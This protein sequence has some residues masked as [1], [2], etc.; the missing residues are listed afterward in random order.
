MTK[1]YNILSD[2]HIGTY[3]VDLQAIISV[4]TGM[5]GTLILNGDIYEQYIEQDSEYFI[6]IFDYIDLNKNITEVIY[7]LG[8]HDQSIISLFP[9]LKPVLYY[10]IGDILIT[11]GHQYDPLCIKEPTWWTK[12]FLGIKNF[13]GSYLG[14]NI[15]IV[16]ERL[17]YFIIRPKLWKV[18]ESAV[19]SNPDKIVILG[20]THIPYCDYPYYNSGG[21]IDGRKTFI[22]ITI[23]ANEVV[24]IKLNEV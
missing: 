10:K 4:I 3:G 9:D 23:D 13:I 7:V 15:K 21:I 12:I 1:T 17:F 19:A 14:F 8:N 18:Q 24:I 20:H 5:E 22:T 16:I 6:N 2:L 11:H